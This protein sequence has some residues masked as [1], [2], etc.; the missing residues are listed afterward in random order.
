VEDL[1]TSVTGEKRAKRPTEKATTTKTEPMA[2]SETKKEVR[3]R[4]RDRGER[5]A[6][7]GGERRG[8]RLVRRH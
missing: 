7:L 4:R 3:G 5:A 1:N 6:R 2:D 8:E